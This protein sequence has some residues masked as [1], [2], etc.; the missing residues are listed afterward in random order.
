MAENLDKEKDASQ[1][2]IETFPLAPPGK[3]FF[4]FPGEEG[5]EVMT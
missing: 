2:R 4:R 3:G 1:L 5:V